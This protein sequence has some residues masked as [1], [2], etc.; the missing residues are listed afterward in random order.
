MF[1]RWVKTAGTLELACA[2]ELISVTLRAIA[3][4]WAT[5][6]ASQSFTHVEAARGRTSKC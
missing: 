3:Y 4:S 5:W 1:R 2:V 6:V